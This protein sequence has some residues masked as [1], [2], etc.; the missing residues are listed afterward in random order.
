MQCFASWPATEL[1]TLIEGYAYML[2]TPLV[3]VLAPMMFDWP[4]AKK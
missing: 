2:W 4:K 1:H 3:L